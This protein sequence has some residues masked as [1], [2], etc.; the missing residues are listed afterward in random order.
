MLT[1]SAPISQQKLPGPPK[2]TA[3]QLRRHG[4]QQVANFGGKQQ[5][6]ANEPP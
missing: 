5:L 3:H 2:V 4:H 6:T 1:A